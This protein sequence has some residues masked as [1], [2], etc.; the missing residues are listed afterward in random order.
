[1]PSNFDPYEPRYNQQKRRERVSEPL[2]IHE[3]DDDDEYYDNVDVVPETQP[4]DEE[5]EQ[6]QEVSRPKSGK[7]PSKI[8]T[9]DEEETLAKSWIKIS[10]DK[11]VGDRQTKMGF[12]RRVLIHFQSLVP[13]TERT[14][15]QLNSK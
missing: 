10:V 7:K 3:E 4:I 15:H 2:P 5:E 9:P 13:R 1:M 11:V 8:W 14:Y 6:V 12:W